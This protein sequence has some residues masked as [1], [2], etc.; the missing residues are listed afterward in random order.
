MGR[1]LLLFF[2]FSLYK[3]IIAHIAHP[4]L[5]PWKNLN[6]VEL[7]NGAKKATNLT[8]YFFVKRRK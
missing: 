8:G 7:Q 2:D 4:P 1:L 3:G 6:L 5:K